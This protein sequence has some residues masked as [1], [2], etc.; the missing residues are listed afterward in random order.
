MD[1]I[2][3]RYSNDG[4]YKGVL[5]FEN[6]EHEEG[7]D[8]TD[9]L[10]ITSTAKP[11]KKE[12]L[13]WQDENGTWREHI[14]DAT[15]RRHEKGRPTVTSTC[16]NSIVELYGIQ[17][18]GKKL[19]GTV[20][21]ILSKLV[22]GTRWTDGA[23]DSFDGEKFELEVWHKNVRECIAELVDLCGGELVTVIT[24]GDY[25]VEKRTVRI[26]EERGSE[27]VRRQF[28]W[29]RNMTNVLRS[30]EADEV[31]TAI[32]GYGKKKLE[33]ELESIDTDNMTA[34]EREVINE[35]LAKVRDNDYAERLSVTVKTDVDL[36]KWG[37]PTSNGMGHTWTT[38]TDDDCTSESFLK[39]QC[40]KQI[41]VLS[42]PL[43]RYEFD[44]AEVD[45]ETWADVK[46]GNSVAVV[47]DEIGIDTIERVSHIRRTLKGRISCRIAI[48]KRANPMVEKFKAAE[49]TTR[50]QTGNTQR[51][52]STAPVTTNGTYSGGSQISTMS[53]SGGG[54]MWTH[55]V[56]GVTQA[57]GTINFVTSSSTPEP[58]PTPTPTPDPEAWGGGGD[59]EFSSSGGGK[60]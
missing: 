41:K 36:S 43:V 46:L 35:K 18:S 16:S 56:N 49:K 10:T 17:A 24:V 8:G 52:Q 34:E 31:Y 51:V 5:D 60:F 42:K 11:A 59:G 32:V 28:T 33:I 54:D 22:K 9:K 1:A 44:V 2:I 23:C 12:R 50:K 55:Q 13:V 57:V 53:S 6:G 19:T 26:V 29:G 15:E 45:A 20:K 4:A 14:V 47:D 38:Y 39:R 48:G 3:L 27:T 30:V 21:G 7:L 25:G 37:T 58:T 40:R